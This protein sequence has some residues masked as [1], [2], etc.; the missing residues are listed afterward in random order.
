[1]ERHKMRIKF[2]NHYIKNWIYLFAEVL[3][4]L[5]ILILV[6][7]IAYKHNKVFDI[8]PLQKY[9]LSEQTVKILK[10]LSKDISINV[11]YEKGK[12]SEADHLLKRFVN[13][14]TNISYSLNNLDKNP[15]AAKKYGINN[16]GES[17]IEC[18]NKSKKI[19]YTNEESIINAI[20]KTTK[21]EVNPI[22]FLTGH[23][24]KDPF[25]SDKKKGYSLLLKAMEL[26]NYT[27]KQLSLS[28][29]KGVPEDASILMICGPE[30]DF[31]QE[32]LA[33]LSNLFNQAG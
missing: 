14:S 29:N 31:S 21:E 17:V 15:G 19:V 25:D 12:R 33:G 27:V 11:F 13:V 24:E 4:L 30:K 3:L 7:L 32:E 22:Y 6:Y 20:L 28:R 1:M 16:Y 26:E 2:Y 18:G 5:S 23:G 9:S 10:N 8:T